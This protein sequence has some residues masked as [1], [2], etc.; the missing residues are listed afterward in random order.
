MTIMKT[1]PSVYLMTCNGDECS[2]SLASTTRRRVENMAINSG[3]SVGVG[4]HVCKECRNKPKRK[5][6]EETDRLFGGF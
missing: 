6:D 2:N 4:R 5:A 3:W 1:A